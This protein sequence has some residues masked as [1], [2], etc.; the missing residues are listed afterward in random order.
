MDAP[1][2]RH[3]D[4]G[5]PRTI[6]TYPDKTFVD[7]VREHAEQKPDATALIFKGRRMS[8]AQLDEQSN[9]LAGALHRIGVKAGD[10]VAMLLPNCP[11]FVISE[12]AIWKLGAIVAPENPIYTDH[13]L[14]E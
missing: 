3:Y 9:A 10:R 7:F 5:V 1:W 4:Q 14:I 11:Q 6:G 2:L 12:L 13:E 8:W